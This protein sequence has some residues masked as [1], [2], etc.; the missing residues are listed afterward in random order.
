[1]NYHLLLILLPAAITSA[2]ARGCQPQ[3]T[4]SLTPRCAS[5]LQVGGLSGAA[6]EGLAE[7]KELH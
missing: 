2:R 4:T 1:M 3:R 7:E 5:S 6:L